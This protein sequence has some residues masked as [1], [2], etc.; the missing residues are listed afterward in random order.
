MDNY[1]D[2]Y[3]RLEDIL[4]DGEFLSKFETQ[5]LLY[6]MHLMYVYVFG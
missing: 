3:N 4:K 1:I 2:V 5:H 6:L